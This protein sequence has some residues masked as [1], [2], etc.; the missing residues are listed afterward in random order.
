MDVGVRMPR[1]A[2]G[3][4]Y[5]VRKT[6][7]EDDNLPRTLQA[8]AGQGIPSAPREPAPSGKNRLARSLV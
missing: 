7:A 2:A 8:A 6:H 5:C 3:T 1:F 4:T